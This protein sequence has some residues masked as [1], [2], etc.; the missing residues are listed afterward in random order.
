MGALAESRARCLLLSQRGCLTKQRQ[1][2]ASTCA[3]WASLRES[4][5]TRNQHAF[6][7]LRQQRSKMEVMIGGG[8]QLTVERGARFARKMCICSI[9]LPTPNPSR[10]RWILD[11]LKKVENKA[12]QRQSDSMYVEQNIGCQGDTAHPHTLRFTNSNLPG[13]AYPQDTSTHQH[14]TRSRAWELPFHF[15][16]R[17]CDHLHRQ[18]RFMKHSTK[19]RNQQNT[20]PWW[21]AAVEAQTAQGLPNP[22]ASE[23]SHQ[24]PFQPDPPAITSTL[25]HLCTYFNH[26]REPMRIDSFNHSPFP[27]HKIVHRIPTAQGKNASTRR[28]FREN[29]RTSNNHRSPPPAVPQCNHRRRTRRHRPSSPASRF[30]LTR[31]AGCG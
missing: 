27:S 8:V 1:K 14:A 15:R 6:G 4:Y 5:N 29:L 28:K 22:R 19:Y 18:H 3:F 12:T 23:L 16:Y 31:A 13:I 17:A 11:T 24:A 26:Q 2:P 25:P 10:L 7:S 30:I 9:G 20:R 21:P